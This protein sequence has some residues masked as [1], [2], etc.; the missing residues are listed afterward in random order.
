MFEVSF[1][2]KWNAVYPVVDG[3][4]QIIMGGN[5]A[6]L[7]MWRAVGSSAVRSDVQL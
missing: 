1:S 7:I 5:F 4:M 6:P 2:Y 3:C